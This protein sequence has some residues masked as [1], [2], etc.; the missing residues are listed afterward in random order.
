MMR[1]NMPAS[2]PEIGQLVEDLLRED[3]DFERHEARSVHRET[4]VRHVQVE[5]R[6]PS[7]SN[8]VA[9]SRNISGQ[10]I[11]LI[12]QDRIADGTSALLRIEGLKMVPAPVVAE[13]RWCKSYGNNWFLSGWQF[14]MIKR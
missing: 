8:M 14:M 2:N 5:V 12:T 13:C 3:A 11:G 10:G 1:T 7:P 9:F 4:I 6:R